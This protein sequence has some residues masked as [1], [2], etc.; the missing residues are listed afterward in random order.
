[1]ATYNN[2]EEENKEQETNG[3]VEQSQEIEV[4]EII[5]PNPKIEQA[6]VKLQR[7]ANEFLKSLSKSKKKKKKKGKQK[8]VFPKTNTSDGALDV[9]EEIETIWPPHCFQIH[10]IMVNGTWQT[11]QY[12]WAC[13]DIQNGIIDPAAFAAA[14]PGQIYPM[15]GPFIPANLISPPVYAA[16]PAGNAS[17]AVPFG[18]NIVGSTAW[19]NFLT[20][21]FTYLSNVSI[22][23]YDWITNHPNNTNNLPMNVGDLVTIYENGPTYISADT[24]DSSFLAEPVEAFCLR[25]MGSQNLGGDHLSL[26]GIQNYQSIFSL[27]DLTHNNSVAGPVSDT[28]QCINEP[29]SWEPDPCGEVGSINPETGGMIFA[30]EQGPNQDIYYEVAPSNVLLATDANGNVQMLP[31]GVTPPGA[32]GTDNCGWATYE[33]IDLWHTTSQSMAE[34]DFATGNIIN[35]PAQGPQWTNILAD[36]TTYTGTDYFVIGIGPGSDNPQ[37]DHTNY[38]QYI[39]PGI[40]TMQHY[41]QNGDD[42]YTY[43]TQTPPQPPLCSPI[44]NEVTSVTLVPPGTPPGPGSPNPPFKIGNHPFYTLIIRGLPNVRLWTWQSQFILNACSGHAATPPPY[45]NTPLWSPNNSC[46][47]CMVPVW[48]T[49]FASNVPAPPAGGPFSVTGLEWGV[50]NRATS[51]HTQADFSGL[52]SPAAVGYKNSLII[53]NYTQSTIPPYFHPTV[54]TRHIAAEESLK[55]DVQQVTSFPYSGNAGIQQIPLAEDESWFLPSLD[56]FLEMINAVGP[57]SNVWNNPLYNTLEH[58]DFK[59]RWIHD[60]VGNVIPTDDQVYWTSSEDDANSNTNGTGISSYTG[61]DPEKF[62]VAVHLKPLFGNTYHPSPLFTARCQPLIARPIRKFICQKE[63]TPEYNYRD[64]HNIWVDNAYAGGSDEQSLTPFVSIYSP[65]GA[66]SG[67]AGNTNPLDAGGSLL[68]SAKCAAGVIGME[69]FTWGVASTDVMGNVYDKNAFRNVDPMGNLTGA[70]PNGFT[71]SIWDNQKQFLGKWHYKFG[72]IIGNLNGTKN[73]INYNGYLNDCATH[74][75]PIPGVNCYYDPINGQ[76]MP[77]HVVEKDFPNLFKLKFW[78]VTHLEGPHPVFRYGGNREEAARR[79][80][81]TND[82]DDSTIPFGDWHHPYMENAFNGW[83]S[84]YAYIKLEATEMINQAQ[85]PADMYNPID[86][87]NTDI[88]SMEVVCLR[89]LFLDEYQG[90]QPPNPKLNPS[91]GSL[92]GCGD[93]SNGLHNSASSPGGGYGWQYA[94][95]T[96]KG[97]SAFGDVYGINYHEGRTQE[98]GGAQINGGPNLA[99]HPK[100]WAFVWHAAYKPNSLSVNWYKDLHDGYNSCFGYRCKWNLG[101]RGP[102]GGIIVGVPNMVGYESVAGGASSN[103]SD[104]YYEMSPVDLDNGSDWPP[105]EYGMWESWVP[106]AN[107]PASADSNVSTGYGSMNGLCYGA[108]TSLGGN[109]NSEFDFVS[110]YT[111]TGNGIGEKEEFAGTSGLLGTVFPCSQIGMGGSV[112]G[113]PYM[114]LPTNVPGAEIAFNLCASYETQDIYGNIYDDWYL[115]NIQESWY[116]MNNAPAGTFP[117]H[118][119]ERDNLYWTSNQYDEREHTP[120]GLLAEISGGGLGP[121]MINGW[122][123]ITRNTMYEAGPNSFNQGQPNP[124]FDRS[125]YAYAYNVTEKVKKQGPITLPTT[126]PPPPPILNWQTLSGSTKATYVVSKDSNLKVRAIRRFKCPPEWTLPSPPGT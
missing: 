43:T 65:G 102:A 35:V 121:Q 48:K 4:G 71:I 60:E 75:S 42:C 119:N 76:N 11:P 73:K 63:K 23:F 13:A 58:D 66:A 123:Q 114:P 92:L 39:I 6:N 80:W 54:E 10:R 2:Q 90:N 37:I 81:T 99:M 106:R 22:E 1:M 53:D 15:Q 45:I 59:W 33:E 74:P 70:N 64:S 57:D 104:W 115:P 101:D 52:S 67:G 28:N 12:P 5:K 51:P 61:G 8:L 112:T 56:E 50:H 91:T 3:S 124:T 17:M 40:T 26:P 78:G 36:P 9:P 88:D 32:L 89:N 7:N 125:K 18:A 16:A 84:S 109:I 19:F 86:G 34:Y 103:D 55:Y 126:P 21:D 93:I 95:P 100:H 41:D 97:N 107:V 14:N 38:T 120:D 27:M 82:C 31:M 20:T 44:Q 122:D 108:V 110:P 87:P 68:D 49:K 94:D 98:W 85:N 72:Q 116:I 83:T 46:P 117:N 30:V 118:P 113:P 69:Y 29:P 96:K 47:T 25:Y 79:R 24:I 62:A 77:Y 105:T 111:V